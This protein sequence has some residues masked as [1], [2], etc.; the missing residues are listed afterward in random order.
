MAA[1]VLTYDLFIDA[2][3]EFG[4]VPQSAI[5]RQ[6]DL[7]NLTLLESA[8]GKWYSHALMLF[9]AHYLAVRYNISAKLAELGLRSPVSSIGTV[10]N[11]S[12]NTS[13]LSEGSATSQLITS[14]NPIEADL[15]R[16]E[17][18]LEYLH[19]LKIVIPPGRVVYSPSSALSAGGRRI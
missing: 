4:D 7:S 9:T 3:P 19:L 1:Y 6:I 10:T 12:A 2:Y 13:G 5:E 11:K 8:W 17:Y 15:A 18:G 14:A 16:T